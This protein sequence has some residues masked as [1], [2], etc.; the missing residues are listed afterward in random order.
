ML[1]EAKQSH[2]LMLVANH[3]QQLRHRLTA[4]GNEP[5]ASSK[6]ASLAVR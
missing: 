3:Q 1:L 4:V 2:A 5:A 6:A